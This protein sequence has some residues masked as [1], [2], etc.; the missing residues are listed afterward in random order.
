MI[1]PK[2]KIEYLTELVV[3]IF[4]VYFSTKT[5]FITNIFSIFLGQVLLLEGCTPLQFAHLDL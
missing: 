3:K 4:D 2:T 5:F 1:D